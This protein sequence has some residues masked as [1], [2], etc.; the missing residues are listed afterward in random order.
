MIEPTEEELFQIY[1]EMEYDTFAPFGGLTGKVASLPVV[2]GA[3]AISSR[4]TNDA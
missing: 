3:V 2:N 1:L 4:I